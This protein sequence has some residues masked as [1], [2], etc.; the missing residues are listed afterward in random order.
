MSLSRRPPRQTRENTQDFDEAEY[1]LRHG[2]RMIKLCGLIARADLPETVEIPAER[3]VMFAANHRSFL[4][5]VVALAVFGKLSVAC[6]LQVRAD[7][8][9]KPIIGGWVHRLRCIPTSRDVREQAE[10]MSLETLDSGSAVAVMPEGR[11]VPPE[12][13]PGGVGQGRIGISR[14]AQQAGAVVIPVAIYGSDKIWPKG[15]PI[16][17]LGLFRRRDLIVRLGPPLDFDHPDHQVNVD[18]LMNTIAAMLA[19]IEAEIE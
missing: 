4:D 1:F 6:R 13:R 3:P 5:I 11:L 12:D 14:I 15:R 16:P 18:Q 9:D 10:A 8:F 17:K 19:D 7:I 2:A